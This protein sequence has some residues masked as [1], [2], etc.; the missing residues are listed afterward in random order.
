MDFARAGVYFPIA[1][2]HYN[3]DLTLQTVQLGLNYR[4]TGSCPSLSAHCWH[5][6]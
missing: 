6:P 2:E 3:S 5:S 4:F 1:G